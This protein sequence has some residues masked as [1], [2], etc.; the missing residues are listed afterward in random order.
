VCSK[1]QSET[2]RYPFPTG[3]YLQIFQRIFVPSPSRSSSYVLLHTT[4][5]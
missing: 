5:A 2:E 1:I 3:K 4:R